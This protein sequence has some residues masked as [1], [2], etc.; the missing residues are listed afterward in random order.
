[1][2]CLCANVDLVLRILLLGLTKDV[3]VPLGLV[4]IGNVETGVVLSES[5]DLGVVF[6]AKG[7]LLEVGL[8]TRVLHRLGDDGVATVDTPCNKNLCG[9][10]AE[11][12]SDFLHNG[13][14]SELWLADDWK[15][16]S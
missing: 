5:G 12:I 14:L 10:G 6:V 13:V 1:M 2:N 11:F 3:D 9:G 8:D 4:A 15:K 16:I 7:N